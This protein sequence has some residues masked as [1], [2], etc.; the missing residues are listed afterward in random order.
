MHIRAIGLSVATVL[1]AATLA[2]CSSG[3][4]DSDESRP[5]HNAADVTFASSMLPH[6]RQG[7]QMA[8]MAGT[9]A[10]DPRIAHWAENMMRSQDPEMQTMMNL[11]RGWGEP[12]P[13]EDMGM[14]P[15]AGRMPGM[16]TDDHLD[17]MEAAHGAS[18][19]DLFLQAMID[20]HT[21]A[22]AVARTEQADGM[23]TDAMEVAEQVERTQTAEV[24]VLRDIAE[25]TE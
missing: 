15:G 22:I 7:I 2:A 16:L 23:N 4:D 20:H 13:D 25:T 11:L 18:F 9:R 6:H 21:G 24:N 5:G 17:Q 3:T 19:D 1:A 12:V 8:H 14:N 10:G